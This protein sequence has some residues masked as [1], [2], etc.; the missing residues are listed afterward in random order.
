MA[1]AQLFFGLTVPG[2]GPVTAQEWHRFA[3]STLTRAFPDG[4]T[5]YDGV[6]QWM[7]PKAHRIVRERSKV[8]VVLAADDA[9]FA[10]NIASAADAYR[11]EFRQ[12][13]VGVVTQQACAAF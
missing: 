6:G 11:R 10:Q 5:V 4:F 1:M 8:V 13:S 9:Q 7:N 2:R 12:Q 3:S